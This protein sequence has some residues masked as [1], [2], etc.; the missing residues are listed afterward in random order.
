MRRLGR[1]HRVAV[2]WLHERWL[3]GDFILFYEKSEL[4]AADIYTKGF[5]DKGKWTAVCWLINVVDPQKLK[6][7]IQYNREVKD[8]L[9]AE[10]AE[11]AAIKAEEAKKTPK[12][13]AAAKAKSKA[14]AKAKNAN[15]VKPNNSVG[16]NQQNP[17]LVVA[18][19]S[20]PAIGSTRSP[21]DSRRRGV[22]EIC[23]RDDSVLGRETP[24]S[25]GCDITRITLAVD[26][27]KPNGVDLACNSIHGP[28][29]VVWASLPCTGGCPWQFVNARKSPELKRRIEGYWALFG[30]MWKNLLKVFA[31]ASAKGATL[32]IEWPKYCRYWYLNRVKKVLVTFGLVIQT[33]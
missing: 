17:P 6:G 32:C 20:V 21:G 30:V 5:S 19:I 1:V 16:H 9:D 11:K 15:D 31:V 27:T 33:S 29:D 22:V 24:D 2:A 8:R 13:K 12:E 28:N 23:A 14:A 4:M 18:D 10:E 25:E 26:F 7:M 3:A